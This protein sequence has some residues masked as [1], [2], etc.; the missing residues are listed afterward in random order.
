[1]KCVICGEK[2]RTKYPNNADPVA[3]GYCCDKCNREVVVPARLKELA[4][5]KSLADSVNTYR[6]MMSSNAY[7]KEEIKPLLLEAEAEFAE[8]D[9]EITKKYGKR[10]Y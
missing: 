1:M 3:K 6:Y 2:I 4:K 10:Q 8:Y 7:S 9:K 5:W